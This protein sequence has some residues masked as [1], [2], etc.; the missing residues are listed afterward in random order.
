MTTTPAPVR[1]PYRLSWDHDAPRYFD[2]AARTKAG[3]GEAGWTV[4]EFRSVADRDAFMAA[5][6]EAA[7][8]CWNR[9]RAG[10]P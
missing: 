7:M 3:R 9:I 5:H 1:L 2:G 8:P 10:H 6:P 4:G